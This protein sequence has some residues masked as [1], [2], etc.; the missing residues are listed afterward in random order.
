MCIENYLSHNNLGYYFAV[1][2][3]KAGSSSDGD[4]S[5]SYVV[6]YRQKIDNPYRGWGFV[7]RRPKKDVF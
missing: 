2:V 7:A 5:G 3:S 1:A 6:K 4:I